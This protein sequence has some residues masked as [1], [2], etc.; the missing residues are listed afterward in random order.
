MK[1]KV[2]ELTKTYEELH[3]EAKHSLKGLE[4]LIER[5]SMSLEEVVA[6]IDNKM[7][8]DEIHP[9]LKN[10]EE[11]TSE[12]FAAMYKKMAE[13]IKA[14]P[15]NFEAHIKASGMSADELALLFESINGS[16]ERYPEVWEAKHNAELLHPKHLAVLASGFNKKY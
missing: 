9:E 13:D 16:I 2:K 10:I 15:E 8:G 3:E 12:D 14:S 11:M 5:N 4:K 1:E 7:E 6:L